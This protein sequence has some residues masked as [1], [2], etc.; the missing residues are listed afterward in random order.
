MSHRSK[1]NT[2]HFPDV[3]VHVC[4]TE[5]SPEEARHSNDLS[6]STHSVF[7][8]VLTFPDLHV[9]KASKQ[10]PF[11]RHRVISPC[12]LHKPLQ[13]VEIANGVGGCV[14]NH[15]YLFIK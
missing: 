12:I 14:L 1:G 10:K 2:I 5:C 4:P 8:I 15:S 7:P 9:I 6:P 13:L 3:D 11:R